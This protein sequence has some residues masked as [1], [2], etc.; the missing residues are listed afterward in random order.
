MKDLTETDEIDITW[1][2]P[3]FGFNPSFLHNSGNHDTEMKEVKHLK[4]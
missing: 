4:G 2:T 3:C 1:L